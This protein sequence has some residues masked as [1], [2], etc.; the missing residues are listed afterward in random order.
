MVEKGYREMEK[1]GE[2]RRKTHLS[3]KA[4]YYMYQVSKRCTQNETTTLGGVYVHCDSSHTLST[5]SP[6]HT[7]THETAISHMST[8]HVLTKQLFARVSRTQM[9][10]S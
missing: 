5:V 8:T 6:A 4:I 9:P 1:V 10:P 2:R 3:C 7:H